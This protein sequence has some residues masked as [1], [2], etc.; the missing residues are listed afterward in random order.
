MQR[1]ELLLPLL[2]KTLAKDRTQFA[3]KLQPEFTG[4]ENTNQTEFSA[5]FWFIQ[6]WIKSHGLNMWLHLPILTLPLWLCY[7]ICH[8]SSSV[9]SISTVFVSHSYLSQ[10]SGLCPEECW[11]VGK[12]GVKGRAVSAFKNVM[13]VPLMFSLQFSNVEAKY[14]ILWHILFSQLLSRR[15]S[16]IS[17][18]VSKS[19]KN[20]KT[21]NLIF[22]GCNWPL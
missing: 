1:Y 9:I 4:K 11:K 2:L 12:H 19:K 7:A 17:N 8:L 20:K 5:L 22:L 3:C 21:P 18:L 14:A 13:N 15:W 6:E 10:W 16:G